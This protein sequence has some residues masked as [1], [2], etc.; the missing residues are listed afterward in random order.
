[1]PE[2]L[3][4]TT[5]W[6]SQSKMFVCLWLVTFV[7][8]CNSCLFYITNSDF[9]SALTCSKDLLNLLNF[10]S[11]FGSCFKL[12]FPHSNITN[13]SPLWP[14]SW[15]LEALH[16]CTLG[17]AFPVHCDFRWIT[18]V[19]NNQQFLVTLV[20][21]NVWQATLHL[22]TINH[23]CAL[24]SHEISLMRTLINSRFTCY[25]WILKNTHSCLRAAELESFWSTSNVDY[26]IIIHLYS[27]PPTP[28][29]S[30]FL[31]LL[32]SLRGV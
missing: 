19:L 13:A 18:D 8:I 21:M 32:L 16:C 28:Q 11:C 2:V 31:C 5:D 29:F 7:K 25:T 9:W 6:L 23:V 3:R 4:L 1:M 30:Y 27:S 12:W 22:V 24:K 15:F 17:K 20:L 14:L 10:L 26:C